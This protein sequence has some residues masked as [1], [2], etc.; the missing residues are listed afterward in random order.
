MLGQL[1]LYRIGE[2]C[3]ERPRSGRSVPTADAVLILNQILRQMDSEL[4]SAV[5]DALSGLDH[6][7]DDVADIVEQVLTQRAQLGRPELGY[8]RVP[9]VSVLADLQATLGPT[10]LGPTASHPMQTVVTGSHLDD[11]S[12]A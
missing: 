9:C 3:L 11:V 4:Y 8:L 1:L 6:P 2:S 7:A 5:L 10:G 12:D